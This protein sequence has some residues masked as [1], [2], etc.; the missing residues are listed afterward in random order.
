E[1]AV[2]PR[3]DVGGRGFQVALDDAGAR[4]ERH[5]RHRSDLGGTVLALDEVFHVGV[6]SG[7]FA[8]RDQGDLL[9]IE[10]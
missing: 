9:V 5:P 4:H 1:F 2:D 3:P 7:R 8:H 10:M 6:G